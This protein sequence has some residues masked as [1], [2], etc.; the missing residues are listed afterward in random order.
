MKHFTDSVIDKLKND[1][2]RM[3]ACKLADNLDFND[4]K[5]RSQ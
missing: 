3:Y 5:F 4:I 1:L 2:N